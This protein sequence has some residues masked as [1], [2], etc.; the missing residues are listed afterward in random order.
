MQPDTHTDSQIDR[1]ATQQRR[2]VAGR[3]HDRTLGV[4]GWVSLEVSPRIAHDAASTIR[5]AIYLHGKANRPNLF[6]KI[7]VTPEGLPAIGDAVFA[8]VPVNATLLFSREQYLAAPDAYVRGI[9]RR[10]EV[11]LNPFVGSVASVFVSRWDTAHESTDQP[12]DLHNQLGIAM[13]KRTYSAYRELLDSD[14]WQRLANEERGP[15]GC[16]GRAPGRRTRTSRTSSTCAR[17]RRR[18]P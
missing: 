2:R 3:E 8:G 14:R 15:R 18:S 16:S 11:G 17:S 6:I 13:A 7:P 10:I 9:E 12:D 4:D 1:L 5:A